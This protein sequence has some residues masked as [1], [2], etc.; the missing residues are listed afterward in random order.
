[1][2][3]PPL[4]TSR[5]PLEC[6]RLIFQTLAKDDDV[7]TLCS[8]L[9]VNIHFHQSVLPYLYTNPF[10]RAF[11][12]RNR[13]LP[14]YFYSVLALLDMLLERVDSD[15]VVQLTRRDP[16]L[17]TN[18]N[19]SFTASHAGRSTTNYLSYL[20]EF[21]VHQDVIIRYAADAVKQPK[22]IEY[23]KASGLLERF[24][25]YG[26][27]MDSYNN[28][29]DETLYLKTFSIIFRRAL[30]WTLCSPSLENFRKLDIP[31]TDIERYLGV[32][33]RLESLS[34]VT[35]IMDEQY[36]SNSL[37]LSRLSSNDPAKEAQIRQRAVTA[38]DNMTLFVKRHT[39][40]FKNVLRSVCHTNTAGWAAPTIPDKYRLQIQQLLPVLS[41]PR[42]LDDGNWMQFVARADEVHVEQ[43]KSIWAATPPAEWYQ[44]LTTNRAPFLPRC[45]NL[46]TY[47]LVTLGPESF[48]W[49][50]EEKR[51]RLAAA[52]QS[53][54]GA[55]DSPPP[56]PLSNI[57]ISSPSD[58]FA[59][60]IDDIAFGF[61]ETLSNFVV[62]E[63]RVP[64]V[65][66]PWPVLRVGRN[67]NLPWL[68]YFNCRSYQRPISLSPDIFS[69]CPFLER[70][71]TFDNL[72][73]YDPLTI[74]YGQPAALHRLRGLDLQGYSALQFHPDTLHT[75]GNLESLQLGMCPS[76]DVNHFIP[77][78]GD[79]IFPQSYVPVIASTTTLQR[80]IWTWDWYLPRI[81]SIELSA[82]FAYTFQFKMLIGC[83]NIAKVSL[84]ISSDIPAHG[85]RLTTSNFEVPVT[86]TEGTEQSEQNAS[87]NPRR[88]VLPTLKSVLL[89]GLW[90]FSD[91]WIQVLLHEVAPNLAE[92]EES[93]CQGFTLEG[94]MGA[95]KKLERL[96]RVFL[97]REY[98]QAD[99]DAVG[100]V[101]GAEETLQRW[102][103]GYT[104]GGGSRLGLAGQ[105]LAKAPEIVH[106]AHQTYFET[107]LGLFVLRQE[108][109]EQVVDHVS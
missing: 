93:A 54:T 44:V 102:W 27:S 25:E 103:Q 95:T 43:V 23:L 88:M 20:Q 11:R 55:H 12:F 80:R 67:W 53:N 57:V 6:L 50:V 48:R 106:E 10:Q 36:V 9:Q 94:V 90:E 49:A 18:P 92:F 4:L 69:G 56:V 104:W 51:Q 29:T 89:I 78:V 77:E 15:D 32:I 42:A 5:L 7:A 24:R 74:E 52:A 71:E 16:A 87:I 30:T 38:F 75:T 81:M 82:T 8:L 21:S 45:R 101:R 100:M 33:H 68:R 39:T 73:E 108:N 58:L 13:N 19:V 107:N 28:L 85:R 3:H 41:Y 2:D 1:M 105:A 84:T 46:T 22:T 97:S 17:S 91:E 60:E 98:S 35:F 26:L 64:H 83:P 65:G 99:L 61:S 40:T 34:D 14:R 79:T 37:D 59:G 31:L 96:E 86:E 76:N 62:H 72:R 70:V 47:H 66:G 63:S 109:V